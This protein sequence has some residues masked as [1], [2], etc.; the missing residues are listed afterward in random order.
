MPRRGARAAE[1]PDAKHQIPKKMLRPSAEERRPDWPRGRLFGGLGRAGVAAGKISVSRN[2]QNVRL[3]P[4]ILAT[5]ELFTQSGNSLG[6]HGPARVSPFLTDEGEHIGDLLIG[7]G[8]FPRLH[9]GG[10]KLST[11]HFQRTD[12]AFQARSF[13]FSGVPPLTNSDPARGGYCP[14][15]PRPVIW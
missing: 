2:C 3:C 10:T 14:A 11:L 9:L 8:S 12:K 4:R 6:G 1:A 7:Q 5:R 13:R 15:T